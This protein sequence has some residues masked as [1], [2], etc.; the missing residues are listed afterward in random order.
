[1]ATESSINS[2]ELDKL[3]KSE[4]PKIFSFLNLMHLL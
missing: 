2:K 1:M 4:I 3:I